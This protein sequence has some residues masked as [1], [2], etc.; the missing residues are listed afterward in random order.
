MLEPYMKNNVEVSAEI[1]PQI[2]GR[3]VDDAIQD[4]A[5]AVDEAIQKKGIAK[6]G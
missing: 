4:L 3:N 2:G 5:G 6:V 1:M